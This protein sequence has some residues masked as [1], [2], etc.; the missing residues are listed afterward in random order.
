MLI[1]VSAAAA[2]FIDAHS[3]LTLFCARAEVKAKY[4]F[5]FFCILGYGSDGR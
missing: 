3:M 5:F 2:Y 4:F 1:R